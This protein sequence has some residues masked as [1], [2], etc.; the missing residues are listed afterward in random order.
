MAFLLN[1]LKETGTFLYD[2]QALH[3]IN[4]L[5]DA[6]FSYKQAFVLEN[7]CYKGPNPAKRSWISDH[8]SATWDSYGDSLSLPQIS[9]AHFSKSLDFS[10]PWLPIYVPGTILCH[11]SHV[12]F[13][14]LYSWKCYRVVGGLQSVY[15]NA[16][17]TLT[18]ASRS[19]WNA[20]SSGSNRNN[21]K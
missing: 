10:E 3:R 11:L 9:C 8:R 14:S 4:S 1:V 13:I 16:G 5:H 17:S 19:Y 20:N 7:E 6:R 15:Y 18:G 21:N 12:L 2:T